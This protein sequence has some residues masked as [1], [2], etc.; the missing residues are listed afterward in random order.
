MQVV[1]TAAP[2]ISVCIANYNGTGVID[3]CIES[4]LR[5][6]CDG[7][8]EIIVHDDASTDSSADQVAVSHPYVRLLRSATNVGFCVSNNRMAAV[9]R[10][11]FLLLLNNDAT[12]RDG[13]LQAMLDLAQSGVPGI[14]SVP[15]YDA[16]SGNLLDRGCRMDC[17]LMPVPI[18]SENRQ[19]AV[20]VMG[21]CL[22][23]P[24]ALWKSVG[25]FP[26]WLGSIGEDVYLCLA[27]WN[28]GLSVQVTAGSGYDHLVG[29]SFGGGKA[30]LG[31]LHT[32]VRRRFLSERN[33]LCVLVVFC[34]TLLLPIAVPLYVSAM[35]AEG[36]LMLLMTRSSRVSREVYLAAAVSA[37]G[38]RSQVCAERSRLRGSL[39]AFPVRRW[40]GLQTF[41]PQKLRAFW[42]YGVPHVR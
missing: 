32:T 18:L 3:R 30:R 33:R 26:E 2:L 24:L 4:V 42:H 13:A 5:Q 22:W 15:Q 34:P 1:N 10:G 11:R 39:G 40:L 20:T 29:F 23:L 27:A 28:A 9:A 37:W 12:L 25:G 31:A 6:R 41:L 8:V 38:L 21:A 14:L 35:I 16:G 36:L 19:S 7:A 17:F